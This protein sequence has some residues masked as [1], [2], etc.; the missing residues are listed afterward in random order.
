LNVLNTQTALDR[1]GF[2]GVYDS[3]LTPVFAPD[4]N[5]NFVFESMHP[6][7]FRGGVRVTF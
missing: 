4:D 1:N 2:V 5:F 6:R 7:V 3:G